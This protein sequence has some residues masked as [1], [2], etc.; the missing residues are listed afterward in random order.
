MYFTDTHTM[1][2]AAAILIGTS[3]CTLSSIYIVLN[4]KHLSDSVCP[5]ICTQW[6]HL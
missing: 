4:A 2:A 6:N 3:Y 5:L 1:Q